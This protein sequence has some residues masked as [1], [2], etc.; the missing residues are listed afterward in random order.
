MLVRIE[1]RGRHS[2][3]WTYGSPVLALLLT[4]LTAGLI[5]AAMG[6]DP[7]RALHTFLV[8]P[9][10]SETGRPELLVKAAP[11]VLIATGLS[12]GFR[13]NV[14]NIGAE[15]QY[16]LGALAGGGLALWFYESEG[17]LLLPAMILAGILGGMAWAAIPAL[18]R[19]R[20]NANE[21]L[22][23]LMLTYVAELVLAYLVT[24][25]WRDPE[26]Y[27]FP[28]SRLFSEAATLPNLVPGTRIHL[29]V[30]VALLVVGLGWALLAK[31]LVGF[32][33][34]VVGQA[35]RAARY[36]GFSQPAL[37]WLTLLIGGGLAGLSGLFE[38][39]GPVGQL[40]PHISPGYGFTA[41]IVAFLGRLHPV[42]VLFAGLVLALSYIGG[43]VAQ[44]ELGLP[45]A[46]TG[47][48]QGILLFFLLACDMLI[49]YRVRFGLRQ[50][51]RAAE[52][53]R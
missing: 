44:I 6:Q 12:L 8:A 4:V 28:Q 41:I 46:V 27:G 34:K 38:V 18:L 24:G 25:P 3:L 42:G 51:A 29:G 39:A 53:A 7:W 21:I 22:T 14:W 47:I 48:F 19:T 20:F 17:P 31:S 2:A 36:A 30:L 50:P 16:I 5:F 52:E 1:P 32:Q 23:S 26:G 15:G 11:L 45:N 49:L 43:E 9:L 40:T 10:A 13:A 33:L 37:V 35:P